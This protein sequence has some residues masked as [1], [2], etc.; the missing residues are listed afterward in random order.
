MRVAIDPKTGFLP[1]RWTMEMEINN[2]IPPLVVPMYTI[3]QVAYGDLRPVSGGQYFQWKI[4]RTRYN[5]PGHIQAETHL[6]IESFAANKTYPS[7]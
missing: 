4:V 5:G 1:V 6:L 3:E 7:E 2:S